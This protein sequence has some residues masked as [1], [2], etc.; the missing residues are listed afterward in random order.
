MILPLKL[1]SSAICLHEESESFLSISPR[2]RINIPAGQLSPGQTRDKHGTLK[3][4]MAFKT[5]L[6]AVMRE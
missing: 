3:M 1:F 5:Q 4:V 6:K 2:H